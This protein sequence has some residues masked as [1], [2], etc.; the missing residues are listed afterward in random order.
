MRPPEVVALEPPATH[1]SAPLIPAFLWRSVGLIVGVLTAIGGVF[2][3]LTHDQIG[4]WSNE[5][6]LAHGIR[7]A[8]VPDRLWDLGLLLGN[9]WFFAFVV[10]ALAIW[11]I[12]RRSWPALI[13]CAS[14]PGAVVLVELVI[15]PLVNRRYEWFLPSTYPSGTAAGVAAWT[16]L[17]WLLAVPLLKSPR[18]R[19]I[20]ALVLAALTLLT[21]VAIVGSEKHLPL[22]ALG[23]VAF[24]I[25][26]V[27]AF[28]AVID[29][30]TGAHRPSG[31]AA[32]EAE[33]A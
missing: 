22:D 32:V 6:R 11:A 19:L 33:V 23:G 13:A 17:T 8:G 4:P 27:L 24:G 20:L 28:T 1:T 14:V 3:V 25:A 26:T 29:L 15:K 7:N 31:S 10:V 9:A 21:A 30:I 12:A 2:A 5:Q 16:T 18:A